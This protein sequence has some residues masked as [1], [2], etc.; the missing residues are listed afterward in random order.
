MEERQRFV[1]NRDTWYAKKDMSCRGMYFRSLEFK[2]E[3]RRVVFLKAQ[4]VYLDEVKCPSVKLRAFQRRI[5][6]KGD[7]D[8]AMLEWSLTCE[9]LIQMSILLPLRVR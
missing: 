6:S 2:I 9:E 7:E 8:E 1:G 4:T 3:M 5:S